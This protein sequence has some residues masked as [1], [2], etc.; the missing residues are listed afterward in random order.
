MAATDGVE[1]LALDLDELKHLQSVAK[2]PRVLSLISAEI[3]KVG[4]GKNYRFS[5]IKVNKEIVPEKCKVMVK[6]TRVTFTLPK[7]SKWNWFRF[8]LQKR[9]RLF[10]NTCFDFQ[11]MYDEGDEE[12][13]THHCKSV[14]KMLDL[15]KSAD[16]LKGYN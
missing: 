13:K 3:P 11:N 5:F 10:L 14:V 15:A 7:A 12:M 2:R 8:A 16:P 6:P 4:E 9:T 1:G